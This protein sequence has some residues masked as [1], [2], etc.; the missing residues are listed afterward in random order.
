MF[1]YIPSTKDDE[2]LMLKS[3]GINNIEQLFDNIPSKL[4]L[5]GGLNLDNSKP[6][7]EVI[8]EIQQIAYKNKDINELVCF[9]GAGAYDHYIPSVIK[10]ITSRSEFYTSYTPYQPEISQ[11]TL[12]ALFEYQTM[13]C[14]LTDMEVANASM[15]DGATAC[16][17][18]AMMALVSTKRKNILVSKTVNPE[19]RKIIET[20]LK[21]HEAELVEVDMLDGATDIEQLKTLINEKTAGVIIQ[22]PNFYG[23]VED[24]TD[25]EK[26][27]HESKALLIMDVNPIALAVLKT[28]GEIGADIVVGE[29]QSLGNSLNFG[30]PY[31]GF[32]A[33]TNKLVRK[34][35]G[36]IVGETVDVD[37]KRAYVLTLQAREQHIRRDKANSNICS[38]QSLNALATAVYL[39]TLGKQGLKEVALQ[40][41]NKSH[42]AFKELTKSGKYKGA[43]NKPFF[44]EFVI[45]SDIEGSK[46]N[47][48]L[49]ENNI[50]GGLE[51]QEGLLF[52][53]TEKRTKEEIDNLVNVMGAIV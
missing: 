21:Y 42:Y 52:C 48:K 3:I 2:E 27:T 11:G 51:I 28:P 18:A 7:L 49:L 5:D 41:M 16:A 31:V 8:K 4:K 22:N 37:G 50:I 30:G 10:Y 19:T 17:E 36:R 32:M 38:N 14:N 9:L 44:M 25:I 29:G 43:F 24:L 40:C 15:Y 35:P 45:S 20:Y 53:V 46:I 23:I 1:P 47:D 39:T 13:I 34:M 26:I 12:Q 33:T 6:E